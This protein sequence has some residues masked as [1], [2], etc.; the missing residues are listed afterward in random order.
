M[1]QLPWAYHLA[2]PS[3]REYMARRYA[4]LLKTEDRIDQA[5]S[6]LG[7]QG[8]KWPEGVRVRQRFVYRQERPK[9]DYSDRTL[10][11]LAERPPAMRLLR[12]GQALRFYL[13]AL[14]AAQMRTRTGRPRN[15]LPLRAGGDDVGWIDLLALPVE[16][17]MAG[18]HAATKSEKKQRQVIDALKALSDQDNKLVHLPNRGKRT[19]KYENFQLL[20][21]GGVRAAGEVPP[22][23]VPR[24]NEITFALP[25]GLFSSGWIHLLESA[26]LAF[27]MMIMEVTR[28]TSQEWVSIPSE[29]RLLHYGI[30]RD[31]HDAYKTLHAFGLLDAEFDED[32]HADGKY[33]GFNEGAKPKP[34]AFALQPYGFD[35]PAVSA[36]KDYLKQFG[37]PP[38]R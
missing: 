12:K 20:D 18:K 5:V 2:T 14:C 13:I 4:R 28:L 29:T 3:E 9:G 26:E 21:E 16:D 25:P 38:T 32:R 10:P 34:H 6:S 1:P 19:G 31:S 22:Y 27:L 24:K 15:D 36:M 11:P 17:Q 35:V 37:N 30:G 8:A 33:R 7:R 23:T